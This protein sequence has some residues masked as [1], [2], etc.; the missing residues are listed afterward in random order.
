MKLASRSLREPWSSSS[1][2][3]PK[4]RSSLTSTSVHPPPSAPAAPCAVSSRWMGVSASPRSPASSARDSLISSS[5]EHSAPHFG[6]SSSTHR[7]DSSGGLPRASGAP[8][9]TVAA[10]AAAAACAVSARWRLAWES[11]GP[12]SPDPGSA[13]VGRER[14]RIEDGLEILKEANA[15]VPHQKVEEL[16]QGA[17]VGDEGL[18]APGDLVPDRVELPAHDDVEGL[19]EGVLHR[20][21]SHVDGRAAALELGQALVDGAQQCLLQLLG[22]A[23]QRDGALFDYGLR[24]VETRRD[25]DVEARPELQLAHAQPAHHLLHLREALGEGGRVIGESLDEGRPVELAEDAEDE[26]EVAALGHPVRVRD[27]DTC[28]QRCGHALAQQVHHQDALRHRQDAARKA[29]RHRARRTAPAAAA[30]PPWSCSG[31]TQGAPGLSWPRRGA[32]ARCAARGPR[33]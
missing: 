5:S 6:H 15:V 30:R 1:R 23:A 8:M 3:M 10:A 32:A 26:G 13:G 2:T 27:H 7:T 29:A 11:T 4:V 28:R 16:A 22:L 20:E 31:G 12:G 25:G 14:C 33:P 19:E 18:G 24:R 21:L 9:G 17:K